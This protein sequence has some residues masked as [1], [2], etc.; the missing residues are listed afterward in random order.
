VTDTVND[1]KSTDSDFY[2]FGFRTAGPVGYFHTDP[3]AHYV[4]APKTPDQY[5]LT[6]LK[7]YIDYKRSYPNADGQLI[8]AKPLF[9]ADARLLLFFTKRYVYHFFEDWPAY[10]GLPAITDSAM[11]VL[12]KDPAEKI[13]LANPPPP[14]ST[15]TEVPRAVTS[16]PTDDDPR[17]PEDIR[18]LMNL[19]NPKL[20][21]PDFM[22]GECWTSGGDM[23]TPASVYTKVIPQNLKPL[24]LYTAVVNNVYRT[25]VQEV[26]RFVFQTSLYADFE[27]QV[28]SYHLDDGKGNKHDAIFR[29]DVPLS[30]TEINLMY[31]IVTGNMSGPNAT[32]AGVW[33]DSFDRLVEGAMKLSPLD[34]PISTEFNIVRNSTTNA[35]VAI[36]IR[37]PEPFNDP[38]L[39]DDVFPRSLR[40]MSGL[41]Q[42]LSYTVLFSRDRS[43]AFVMHPSKIIPVTQLKFRF[44]YI[45]WDG[46][47]YVERTV[48][49]SSF[50]PTNI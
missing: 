49:I 11:Q 40:V 14:L 41:S 33:A 43:Q 35:V 30:A 22:G 12:I 37:S 8:G 27:A 18:T 16:W 1:S 5:M 6:G 34:A 31:D 15:T 32:L 23:I 50:I 29:I 9:Y 36:W 10:N 21:N 25:H 7:G 44:A 46:F 42:N 19:R 17:M 4:V 20:L 38:K 2:Y 13:S 28:N 26:H 48:I 39:P 47:D 3:D 24:K 45:E